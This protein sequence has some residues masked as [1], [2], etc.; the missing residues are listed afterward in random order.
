VPCVDD[1]DL[2]VLFDQIPV[3]VG[4]LD[5]VHTIGEVSQ[6]PGHRPA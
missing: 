2:A 4:I 3:D 5:A 6:D 1:G